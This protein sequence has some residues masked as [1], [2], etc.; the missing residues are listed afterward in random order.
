M[1]E[2]EQCIDEKLG[3]EFSSTSRLK[4]SDILVGMLVAVFQ[5]GDFNLLSDREGK[6][7]MLQSQ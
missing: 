4:S 1:F 3:S 6:M 5:G 7:Q 2:G